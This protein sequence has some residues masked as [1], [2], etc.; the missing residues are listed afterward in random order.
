MS[1]VTQLTNREAGVWTTLPSCLGLK[2]IRLNYTFFLSFGLLSHVPCTFSATAFIL[3]LSEAHT[4]CGVSFLFHSSCA[5]I[6]TMNL[7]TAWCSSDPCSYFAPSFKLQGTDFSIL[8]CLSQDLAETTDAITLITIA[9]RRENGIRKNKNKRGSSKTGK[10]F[11][12]TPE[13]SFIPIQL[14]LLMPQGWVAIGAGSQAMWLDQVTRL[15]W[16]CFPTLKK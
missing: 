8:Q 14:F 1:K 5:P 15:P 3:L 12:F 9:E 7:P 11:L 2:T 13:S 4:T 10:N 6:S 16:T